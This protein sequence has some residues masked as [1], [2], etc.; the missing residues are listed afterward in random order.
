MYLPNLIFGAAV[1]VADIVIKRICQSGRKISSLALGKLETGAP[2]RWLNRFEI[3]DQLMFGSLVSDLQIAAYIKTNQ[4]Y[5]Y[6]WL[7]KVKQQTLK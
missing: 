3:R 5:S 2:E 1:K 4:I 7:L 6:I